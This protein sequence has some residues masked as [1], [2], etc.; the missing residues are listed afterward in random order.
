MTD[1]DFLAL[2]EYFAADPC[3]VPEWAEELDDDADNMREWAA[4]YAVRQA[5]AEV[6]AP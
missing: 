4:Y 3:N 2:T 6:F 1:P 5:R